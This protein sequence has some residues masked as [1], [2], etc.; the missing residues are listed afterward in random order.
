MDATGFGK[1]VTLCLA[2]DTMLGRG[3]VEA[4]DSSDPAQLFSS[5][6]AELIGSADLTMV[7]LECCISERGERWPEPGKLHHIGMGRALKGTRIVLL[8]SGRQVRIIDRDGRLL[9]NFTLDPAQ[10]YQP[11][12]WG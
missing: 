1:T 9:R 10:D 6:V 8:V 3:V 5:E 12:G 4:I 11:Q 7:N 2:G